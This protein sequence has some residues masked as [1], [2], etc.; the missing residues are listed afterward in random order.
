MY[1]KNVGEKKIVV[2]NK[3][4]GGERK[5][6]IKKRWKIR[7]VTHKFQKKGNFMCKYE[8]TFDHERKCILDTQLYIRLYK[9]LKHGHTKLRK[10][11]IQVT[12]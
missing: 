8:N 2:K 6:K 7:L 9:E 4:K 10:L 1:R 5:Y 12:I 3:R 11:K